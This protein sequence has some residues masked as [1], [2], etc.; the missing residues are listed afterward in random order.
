[1]KNVTSI[2]DVKTVKNAVHIHMKSMSD[3]DV[4]E[5]GDIIPP[6]II[7]PAPT[8]QKT[9]SVDDLAALLIEKNVLKQSDVDVKKK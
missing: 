9:L 6:G 2:E 1:M 4:Y 8:P 3:I 7:P 5:Y